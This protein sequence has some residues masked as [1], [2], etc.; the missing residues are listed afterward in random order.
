MSNPASCAVV[1]AAAALAACN[2]S[3][4]S[5]APEAQAPTVTGADQPAPV[6]PACA[7]NFAA[8]DRDGDHRISL[9]EFR[10][11][12]HA[13]PDPAQVFMARD[14]NGDGYLTLGEFC[15][16]WQ[17]GPGA[18]YGPGPGAGM[19]PHRG[20]LGMGA[21]CQDNF[22]AFD[23]NGDGLLTEQELAAWPHAHGDAA[24]IFAAR[25]HDHDGVITKDEFCAPWRKK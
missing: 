21:R 23:Q 4:S 1:V 7:D 25:D 19:G 9:D 17:A 22:D 5:P 24:S 15:A 12:P 13:S 2:P 16:R 14:R 20:G 18:P 11:R 3:S 6:H 10:S 8:F